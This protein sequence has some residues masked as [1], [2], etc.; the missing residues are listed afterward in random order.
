MARSLLPDRAVVAVIGEDAEA[1]LNRLFTNSMLA[2]RDGEAR[3][4]AL[5]S[6][7]GKLLFDFLALRRSD[8][9]WLDCR[10]DQAAELAKRLSM[11][12]LR[13]KAT[14]E[15]LSIRLAVAA[16][17]D[18]QP[19][20]S[21]DIASFRDPRHDSL[22]WR[23]IGPADAFAGPR[24]D[25]DYQAHRIAL[26][27]PQGGL[28]WE[29]GDAFVHDANLDWLHGVDFAKGCYVGQE[30]VSRVH[31]RGS[32][33]KRIVKLRFHGEPPAT[34]VELRAGPL[35][36][37]RLTSLAGSNGL[38]SIR[39]DRLQDAAESNLPVTAGDTLVEISM[40]AHNMLTGTDEADAPRM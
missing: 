27:V 26:G 21:G 39:I 19:V 10:R 28:D 18:E 23:L 13:A 3:Y 33:R 37:G 20:V 8:G 32:A 29:N 30:V 6:P 4:A 15:D 36:L 31:H 24:S 11:F 35:A 17:W 40:P 16:V 38:A 14:V 34:G 7:Q 22:G 9:F 2:M 12:K 5:L 25:E 1:L